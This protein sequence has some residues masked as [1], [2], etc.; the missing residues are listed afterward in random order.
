MINEIIQLITPNGIYARGRLKDVI[1]HLR[2]T[3]SEQKETGSIQSKILLKDFIAQ[4]G[5]KNL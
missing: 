3:L 2:Q 4:A 1:D 5:E